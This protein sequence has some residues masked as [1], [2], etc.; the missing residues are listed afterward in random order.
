MVRTGKRLI[1]ATLAR[2]G[3][4]IQPV[5]PVVPPPPEERERAAFLEEGRLV[6]RR[7]REQTRKTVAALRRKYASPVL[8]PV[9]VWTLLERLAECIDP[10]DVALQCTSQQV[11]VLQVLAAMEADGITDPHLLTAALIH[12][13]GKVLLLTGEAPENVVCFNEPIG[14]HEPGI[15]LDQCVLQWNH[16]E[17]GYSRLKDEVPEP[18][19]W[20]VRYHSVDLDRCEPLMDERDREYTERYLLPFQRYDQGSK[21]PYIIPRRRLADYRDLVERLLPRTLLF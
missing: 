16:D 1:K 4:V 10:T 11:H 21:S 14:E 17:F 7:H 13:V 8:G 12:D 5:P 18:V 3:Y 19:A 2:Y 20:L 6:W 15:G 9:P